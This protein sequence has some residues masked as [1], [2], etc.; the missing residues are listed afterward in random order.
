[1]KLITSDSI[2]AILPEGRMKRKNGLDKHGKPMSVRGGVA[3]I[4]EVMND[5][6][7]LF[8]YSG[9]LHHIQTPGQVF[10]KLFKKIKLSL[11]L[12]ELSDYKNMMAPELNENKRF[13][14]NV[15]NDLNNRL[16]SKIP[17]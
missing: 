9:G 6:K 17:S 3:D 10:P 16:T 2:V 14:K 4:L 8:V 1:M 15:I 11:E 5:G 13:R 7:I 12:V